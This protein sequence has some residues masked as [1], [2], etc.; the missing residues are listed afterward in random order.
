LSVY[1]DVISLDS[2]KYILLIKLDYLVKK[3]K[4]VPGKAEV[5]ILPTSSKVGKECSNNV[6]DRINSIAKGNCSEVTLVKDKL[7]FSCERPQ[8]VKQIA[9]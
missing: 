2:D 1:E 4:E 7:D 9:K 8:D 6:D 3:A 5:I